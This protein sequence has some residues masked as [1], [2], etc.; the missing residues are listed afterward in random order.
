MIAIIRCPDCGQVFGCYLVEKFP[1]KYCSRC[2][3]IRDYHMECSP[4]RDGFEKDIF[5]QCENCKSIKLEETMKPDSKWRKARLVEDRD[6]QSVS[7]EFICLGCAA[8]C[9]IIWRLDE[10]DPEDC[11]FPDIRDRNRP[12]S[13]GLDDIKKRYF[14]RK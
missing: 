5:I 8:R 4:K 10:P 12:V 3:L 6:N 13:D 11:L 7:Q 9:H 2:Y 14:G 1:V